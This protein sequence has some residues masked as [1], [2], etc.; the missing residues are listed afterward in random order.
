MY[1]TVYLRDA[2]KHTVIPYEY[3]YELVEEN[4]FNKGINTNQ[5][6]L[7]FFSQDLFDSFKRGENPNL[8]D[9][10]PNFNCPVEK[11]YP[12]PDDMRS[13]CF[14]ARLIKFWCKYFVSYPYFYK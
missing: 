7:I 8:L 12:L 14:V 2:K 9:F 5:N 13:A 1:V 4:L 3:V 10:P 11:V 6:R